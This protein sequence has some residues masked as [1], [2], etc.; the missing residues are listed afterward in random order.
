MHAP[1]R[2]RLLAR[3]LFAG[4][5]AFSS[6]EPQAAAR[7]EAASEAASEAALA[8]T[9]GQDSG[10][11]SPAAGTSSEAS[12]FGV[13]DPTVWTTVGSVVPELELPLVDGSGVFSLSSLRGKKI[14]L[15]QF[16]SW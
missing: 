8:L 5:L 1:P 13:I 3:V 12:P 11:S 15:I 16:A 7:Q 10:L 4:A 6:A 2:P 9:A 14:L